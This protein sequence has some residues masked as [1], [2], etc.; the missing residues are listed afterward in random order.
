MNNYYDVIV[1]GAGPSA[2]FLAYEMIALNSKKKYQEL[3]KSMPVNTYYIVD[4]PYKFK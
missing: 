2:V 3:E 4:T 1:V